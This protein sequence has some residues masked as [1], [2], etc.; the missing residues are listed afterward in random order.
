[1]YGMPK[2]KN[3][4]A[5]SILKKPL[6]LLMMRLVY[7]GLLIAFL[8]IGYLLGK[9]EGENVATTVT[10]GT[11]SEN[12]IAGQAGEN[13]EA[14][15]QQ[16]AA[17]DPEEILKNLNN[18]HLPV[19]GDEDAPVT[20]IEFSDFEC[21]FCGRFYNDTLPKIE[22]EYINTGKVK[23]YYRHLP[24]TF[25]PQA[26]PAA[27]ASECAN[28]QDS[29]WEYHDILFDNQTQFSTATTDTFV[30]WAKDLGLDTSQF[31]SCLESEKYAD[32]V[33]G[34]STEASTVGA[35]G[36]PTFYINGNQL[37]GAQPFASFKAI[38]D[39]ELKG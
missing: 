18:G 5:Y 31:K 34:D 26:R 19:K 24:L 25:H 22:E 28:E 32:N 2:A 6:R 16:P 9:L 14:I 29:F 21:P 20:M 13:N 4:S 38:I 7:V 12:Q 33:D 36:T 35:S 30:G 37:V 27:L 3:S 15:P 1:M 8:V 39:E 17:P 11:Q 23:I 10:Q